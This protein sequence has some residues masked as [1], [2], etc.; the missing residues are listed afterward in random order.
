M[1]DLKTIQT[2]YAD[3]IK[4]GY[5]K[6]MLREYLQY[7]IL[8]IIFE[9]KYATK[10]SFL[11][12]TALRI[13]HQNSRFSENLDFDNFNLSESEFEELSLIIKRGLELE[14]CKVEVR[15]IFKNAYHC[16]MRLPEILYN[17]GLAPMKNEKISILVDTL[18]HEFY[19]VADKI[20]LNKFDVYT[21]I[22]STPIDILL[23]QK[24]YAVFNRKTAKGR[25]FYDIV[26]LLSKA[27]P[28]MDYI[29]F[30]LN[31][32]SLNKLRSEILKKCETLDFKSLSRDV[33]PFL[34]NPND[35]R[36]AQFVEYFKSVVW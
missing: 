5:K 27:K 22:L 36:V 10:M 18:A 12:G 35:T 30:K 11:G 25:D 3:Q 28:N 26:F 31:I 15:T 7:K 32:Q 13:V 29:S 33:Q 20:I 4:D 14:G 1:L 2:F 9:S 34:F 24:F 19:Y 8:K 17:S 23:A 6:S 21:T 16:D